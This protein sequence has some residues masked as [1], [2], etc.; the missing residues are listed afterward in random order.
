MHNGNSASN[1]PI[2]SEL[3]MSYFCALPR[4]M[5]IKMNLTHKVKIQ[6]HVKSD[7]FFPHRMSITTFGTK[8]NRSFTTAVGTNCPSEDDV[9]SEMSIRLDKWVSADMIWE[10]TLFY[11]IKPAGTA[12]ADSRTTTAE[13]SGLQW[14]GSYGWIKWQN[15]LWQ[16]Q[17]AHIY[18]QLNRII[19]SHLVS[20]MCLP[21]QTC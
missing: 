3:I 4:H 5:V 7:D 16:A 18:V 8:Q 6:I 15:G 12:E 20:G 17:M 9:W 11:H 10:L 14:I 19:K 21:L 13:M 1:A 2:M